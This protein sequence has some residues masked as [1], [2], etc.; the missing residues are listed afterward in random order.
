MY[1]LSVAQGVFHAWVRDSSGLDSHLPVASR[2][3]DREC[4]DEADAYTPFNSVATETK[5]KTSS[6]IE[7]LICFTIIKDSVRTLLIQ[8]PGRIY[9]M[10]GIWWASVES[11]HLICYVITV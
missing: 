4:S 1:V 3:V 9:T 5:F 7:P 8:S 2:M 10:T 11:N 6:G